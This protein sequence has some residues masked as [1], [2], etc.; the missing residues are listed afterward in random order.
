LDWAAWGLSLFTDFDDKAG[1]TSQISNYI[2]L[3]TATDSGQYGNNNEGFTWT[4][5]TPTSDATNTTTGIY[6]SGLGAG[7]EVDV[8]ATATTRILTMYVGAYLATAHFEASLSDGSAPYYVDESFSTSNPNGSD[9]DYTITY[10]APS[11][12]P[13]PYLIVRYWQIEG[14]GNVT[15]NAASLQ[16]SVAVN[17]TLQAVAGNNLQLTW[18][19]GTLMQA[20]NL[21]GPWVTN[22]A[23]S[24]YTF[25]P[26]GPQE[27]FRVKV[28]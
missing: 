13:K 24:P 26:A 20:A 28:Q 22:G 5:G 7:Y 25:A 21:A 23:P 14:Q 10:A 17:L 3:G 11:L 4:D 15:L 2:A 18:P 16:G 12:G 1:V 6:V 19:Q 27:F 8:P 9:C